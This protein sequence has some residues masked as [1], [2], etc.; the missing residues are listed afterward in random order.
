ME[1]ISNWKHWTEG[2][3][4]NV[5]TVYLTGYLNSSS[6]HSG[7][8]DGK[9]IRYTGCNETALSVNGRGVPSRNSHVHR[10]MYRAI[11]LDE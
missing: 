5:A 7:S 8:R 10:V 2:G 6:K 9:S 1:F 3:R 4:K 11:D